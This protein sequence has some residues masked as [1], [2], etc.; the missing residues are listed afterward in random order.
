MT[1]SW[2]SSCRRRK[3]R[4]IAQDAKPTAPRI[5][6]RHASRSDRFAALHNVAVEFGNFAAV[7]EA[8]LNEER[9]LGVIGE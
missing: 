3:R 7:V 2:R 4:P 9:S 1:L 8:S 6:N 5:L